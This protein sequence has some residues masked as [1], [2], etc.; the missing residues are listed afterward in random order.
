MGFEAR[1]SSILLAFF[2][3]RLRSLDQQ[4]LCASLRD[5]LRHSRKV[6]MALFPLPGNDTE[7][8]VD[9]EELQKLQELCETFL[10][11]CWDYVCPELCD[12]VQVIER[13]LIGAARTS[14]S[15]NA[16]LRG[17]TIYLWR[18]MTSHTK[19]HDQ[20]MQRKCHS[21]G[22][23]K[24]KQKTQHIQKREYKIST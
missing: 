10:E 6:S 9:L 15:W 11:L 19:S 17:G 12:E 13:D 3:Q 21:D 20:E 7:D 2:W 4:W 5:L 16:I 23:N 8:E 18:R 24:Q 14:N 1:I 22:H